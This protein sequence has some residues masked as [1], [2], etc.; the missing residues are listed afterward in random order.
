MLSR[1]IAMAL[2]FR[3][4]ALL[5]DFWFDEVFSYER[6]VRHARSIGDIFFGDALK[7]DNNHHLNTLTLYLLGEQSNWILYRLPSLIAAWSQSASSCRSVADVA[8]S[9]A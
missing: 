7:H 9:R 1:S 3:L 2:A 8:A 5:T 4:P 6:F